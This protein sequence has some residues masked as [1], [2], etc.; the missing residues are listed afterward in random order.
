LVHIVFPKY[1]N[2][3]KELATLSLINRQMMYIHTFFIALVLL[4]MGFLCLTSSEEI[5]ATKLGNRLS[6][7]FAIFWAIRLYIQF[8]GYSPDIWKGKKFEGTIHILFSLIWLYF[9]AV[10]FCVYFSNKV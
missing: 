2:W 8:F 1:F 6:L 4:L 3:K 9:S 5:I 7:G 10:F